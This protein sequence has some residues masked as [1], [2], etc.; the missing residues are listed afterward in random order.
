MYKDT[1]PVFHLIF[2]SAQSNA[3]I[4]IATSTIVVVVV[5]FFFIFYCLDK[6]SKRV[7]MMVM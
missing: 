6:N 3:Q 4:V 1:K 7:H 5:L 2:A